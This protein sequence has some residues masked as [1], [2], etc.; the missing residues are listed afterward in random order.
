MM[1]YVAR[2]LATKAHQADRARQIRPLTPEGSS[3]RA[4]AHPILRLQRTAG[5]RAVQRL[6]RSSAIQ[7]KLKIGQP[8]DKYEQEADRVADLVMC[9]PEPGIQR[10]PT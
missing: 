4:P 7:A 6:L 10:K 2:Q 9:M 1:T 3:T 5:N 8:N